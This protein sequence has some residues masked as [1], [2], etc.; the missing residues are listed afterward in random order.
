M[1]LSVTLLTQLLNFRRRCCY[2]YW[3]RVSR[4]LAVAVLGLMLWGG[5]VS[6]LGSMA[7][8]QGQLF[9]IGALAITAYLAGWLT[10][11]LQLPSLLGMMLAGIALRNVGFVVLTGGYL[12][13]AATL[14]YQ[15]Y[16]RAK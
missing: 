2:L 14:R 7:S 1:A 11:F 16:E 8:P 10:S 9:Q 4:I 6:K 5:A 12:H 13:V 3:P 15:C